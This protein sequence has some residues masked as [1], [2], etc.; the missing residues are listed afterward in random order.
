MNDAERDAWLREALRH[1]PDVDAA[2][3]RGVSEAILLKARAAARGATPRRGTSRDASAHPLM[4]WWDWLARP[5]VAAGFA[6]VMAATL[7]GLMWW[8]RPMDEAMPRSPARMSDRAPA[9]P[10]PAPTPS[11]AADTSPLAST[12]PT[13]AAA[14]PASRQEAIVIAPSVPDPRPMN[15]TENKAAVDD[16]TVR[17]RQHSAPEQVGADPARSVTGAGA[18]TIVSSIG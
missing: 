11:A 9:A 14:P 7:V 10:S 4:A 12:A 3:P 17:R 8:D 5:P 16:G 15:A 18:R 13:L 6:S 2:P 1:A